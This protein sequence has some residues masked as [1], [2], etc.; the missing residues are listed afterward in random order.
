MNFLSKFLFFFSYFICLLKTFKFLLK[1]LQDDKV[2]MIEFD[3]GFLPDTNRIL[4]QNKS[5][6]RNKGNTQ[7]QK[8]PFYFFTNFAFFILI[9]IFAGM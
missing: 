6:S 7:F 4:E 9:K 2:V 3:L 5:N 1:R 8:N